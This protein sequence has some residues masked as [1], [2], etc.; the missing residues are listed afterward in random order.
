MGE[1]KSG[2]LK[3]HSKNVFSGGWNN[4]FVKLCQDSYLLVYKKQ[5]DYEVKAKICL[6][7][8]C[9]HFAYGEHTN[10]FQNRPQ[11]PAGASVSC[12]LAIPEKPS[13]K[14]KV[15]WFL[16]N[17]EQHLHEWMT[18]ICRTLPSREQRQEASTSYPA[19]GVPGPYPTQ[20]FGMPQPSYGFD[21]ISGHP[22]TPAG[23]IPPTTSYQQAPYPQQQ[24]YY[25]QQP[26]Y[27]PSPGGYYQQPYQQPYQ[28]GV[29]PQGYPTQP[30]PGY[31]QP[32]AYGYQQPPQG[33]YAQQPNVVYVKEKKKG[34]LFSGGTG[35]GLLSGNTGKVVAGLAGGALLGYG[36]SRMMGRGPFGWGMGRWGSWSSLS[37][38]GSVGSFGSFGSFD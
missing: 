26:G 27:Q 14:A 1:V 32:A 13:H 33:Y 29:A 20:P 8:V 3:R 36:A 28:P 30:P 2:Y 7:D 11:V 15:H 5:G 9:K 12:L 4:V 38:M 23:Y 17:N 24:G 22:P 37:S 6:K 16:C 18:A 31:Q 21:G 10:G 25:P 35:G 34:G 19:S